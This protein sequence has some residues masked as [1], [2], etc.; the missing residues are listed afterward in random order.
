MQKT[1]MTK[2]LA[3]LLALILVLAA[4]GQSGGSAEKT[5]KDSVVMPRDFNVENMDYVVTD[6]VPDHEHTVNFVDNL[7]ENDPTGKLV[8]SLASEWSSNDDKSVWTFKIKEGLKWVT[9]TGEEWTEE[10]TA[11]DFVTGLRHGAEFQSSTSWLL[12][13]IIKGYADYLKSDKSDEAWSKVGVKAVDPLTLEFT[14]EGPTPYF[15]SMTTYSVMAPIN[16]TFLESKGT[17][18]KLGAPDKKKCDFGKV[19]PDSILYNGAYLLE[20]LTAKS[21]ITY[22]K[23]DLYWDADNVQI[24]NVKWVY[25][26]GQDQYSTIRG[27]ENGTYEQAALL[28]SWGDYDEYLEK[29]KDNAFI[30]IPNSSTFGIVMNM[31]RQSFNHT[32]YA[33]DEESRKNTREALQ[34]DNFRKALRSAMDAVAWLGS[35]APEEVAKAQ[36]RNINNFPEAGTSKNGTYFELVE[37]AYKEAT[38][39][40]VNLQ[41]G[42]YPWLSKED[43]LKYIEAAKKDGVKFP[44]HLDLIVI[45]TRKDLVNK[46][47]SM[48][49]S[50]KLNTDEQIIVHPVLR[51]SDIVQKVG[52]QFN[53]PKVADYDISTFSGWGPDFADPKSFAETYHA[54]HGPYM[55]NMGLG[56][57]DENKDIKDKIG[58]T[59]YTE[60]IEEAD[61]IYDDLDARY[62]AYAKA[63]AYL[64]ERAFFLPNS[65]Q[66]RGQVVSRF[67]PFKRPFAYYGDSEFKLKGM[68]IRDEPITKAEFD[69]AFEKWQKAQAKTDK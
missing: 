23:N 30:Q 29:Y 57:G 49:Q 50:I 43:A 20:E 1:K 67:E 28:A 12:S 21:Q 41:D 38:G 61:K 6:K 34:N 65:Q 51:S 25:S 36:I 14:L 55:K 31:N 5:A 44:V 19:S 26:D 47:N 15:A 69:E 22:V 7:L 56:Q 2:V 24:N 4:C 64:I 62:E 59:K 32:A 48:A 10:V 3:L 54:E 33:K 68:I 18:C 39:E 13:G 27:F 52:F 16:K 42:Q 63:D 45:E 17:G 66:T 9:N 8:P 11:E 60:M 35:N 46:G 37:K 40:E 53:D 58:L